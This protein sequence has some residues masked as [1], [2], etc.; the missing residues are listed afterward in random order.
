[1][2]IAIAATTAHKGIESEVAGQADV[3]IMP[4][5]QAGNIFY[6][7]A[8]HAAMAQTGTIVAGTAKPAVM[9]SRSDSA[10]SKLGYNK[11][12]TGILRLKTTSRAVLL[13]LCYLHFTRMSEILT[14]TLAI[15]SLSN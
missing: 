15:Y 2:I 4:G 9:T 13:L 14:Q 12:I 11:S 3:L 1:M 10:E 5:I 7:T 6:K 8:I